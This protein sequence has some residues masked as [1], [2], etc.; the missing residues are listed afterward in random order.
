[1][2]LQLNKAIRLCFLL[3]HQ[4]AVQQDRPSLRF[5]FVQFQAILFASKTIM[6]QGYTVLGYWWGPWLKVCL[7]YF[8][9]I[10][11]QIFE[12]V[13]IL[14]FGTVRVLTRPTTKETGRPC[15]VA[16]LH[17]PEFLEKDTNSDV[18]W[19]WSFPTVDP[20]IKSLISKK[21]CL[22]SGE[23]DHEI[24]VPFLYGQH[25]RLWYYL[26]TTSVRDSPNLPKVVFNCYYLTCFAWKN[27]LYTA[28]FFPEWI[29]ELSHISSLHL[30]SGPGV[31]TRKGLGPNILLV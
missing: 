13:D 20:A 19:C 8:P 14:A 26:L 16:K 2:G 29:T 3:T 18:L 21:C 22:K 31:G 11:L 7:T 24:I 15:I 28:N 30:S 5:Y 10:K 12:I 27:L 4:L 23:N 6:H 9:R 25:N 1:M 17:L